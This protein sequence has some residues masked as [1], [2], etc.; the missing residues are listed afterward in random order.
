MCKSVGDIIDD[1]V[2]SRMFGFSLIARAK[3]CFQCITNGTIQTWKELEDKFLKRYYFN[4]QFVERKIAITSFV[5]EE[6]MPLSDAWE[7]FKLILRKCLNHNTGSIEEITHFMDGL[8]THTRMF[9]DV[10]VWGT[11][12]L[13]PMKSWKHWLRTCVRM[14]IIQASGNETKRCPFSLF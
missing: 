2:K 5:Q 9:L 6:A 13:K 8:R 11:L 3:D 12:R 7:R 1:Q 4:A 10:S 14:S